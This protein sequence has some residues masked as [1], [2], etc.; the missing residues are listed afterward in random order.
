MK[1][2]KKGLIAYWDLDY[3]GKLK[4][5]L[6]MLPFAVILCFVFPFI[7]KNPVLAIGFPIVTMITFIVQLLYTYIMWK[8]HEKETDSHL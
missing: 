2:K 3:K 7:I 1:E 4:R 6:W 8:K 5:T